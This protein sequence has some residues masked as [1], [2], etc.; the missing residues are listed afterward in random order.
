[1]PYPG[2]TNEEVGRRGKEIYE[3]E[4]RSQVESQYHG[5]FL[6]VDILTGEYE[7][8]DSNLTAASRMLAKNP[9]AVLF[10]LRIGYPAAIHLRRCVWVQPS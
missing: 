4:I 8:A 1:M 7:I 6:A 3:K 10:G 9:N 2:Y 5:R